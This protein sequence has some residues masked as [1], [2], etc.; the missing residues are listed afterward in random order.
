MTPQERYESESP[1]HAKHL[2]DK[3]TC[4]TCKTCPYWH[5][6]DWNDFDFTWGLCVIRA[7]ATIAKDDYQDERP[8]SIWPG[9]LADDFCGEH[10]DFQAWTKR[11]TEANPS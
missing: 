7:P 2:R 9:T 5:L 8:P 4:P 1:F 3:E 6:M 10:P 11:K